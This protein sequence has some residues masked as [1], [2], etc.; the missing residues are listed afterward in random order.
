MEWAERE[1]AIV[2][3]AGD[4][5]DVPRSWFLCER[6]IKFFA[7]WNAV[8]E[9][10]AVFGQHDT[11]MYSE[12]TRHATI[13][14]ILDA[15]GLVAILDQV[16]RT[17][18]VI[19]YGDSTRVDIYGASYGQ[20]VPQVEDRKAFNVLVIHKMIVPAKAWPGQQDY[21]WAPRFLAESEHYDLILCGDLHQQYRFQATKQ[22]KQLRFLVN[23]GCMSRHIADEYNMNHQPGFYVCDTE[24]RELLWEAIPHQPAEEVLSRRHL[25]EKARTDKMLDEFIQAMDKI[26]LGEEEGMSFQDHMVAYA[27]EVGLSSRVKQIIAETID[28]EVRW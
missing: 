12:S 3:Q 21:I 24:S 2:L 20:P 27:R 10:M 19:L 13:L 11:Y 18:D 28:E 26:D 17:R 14:G 15:N 8:V 5:F 25:E 1:G 23:T 6:W 7:K 16:P 4:F 22:N 9:I